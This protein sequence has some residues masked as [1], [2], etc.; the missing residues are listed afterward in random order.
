LRAG[1]G[2]KVAIEF[3][4]PV[5]AATVAGE[6]DLTVVAD[7][8]PGRLDALT[9]GLIAGLRTG[10]DGALQYDNVWLLPT[11][12]N[13]PGVFV[14]GGARG[15]SEWREAMTDGLAVAGQ[16]HD[17]L[18]GGT[19]APIKDA[20]TVD[21]DKCVL[22]LTC[23]RICPHGAIRIDDAKK[24]ASVSPLSCRRCGICA[25]EC[26]AVAIQLPGFSDNQMEARIGAKPRVTVFACENSAFPAA[27]T[28]GRKAAAR[29][30]MIKVPCAGK[31]D[32]RSVLDALSRGADKVLVLGCHPENCQ[33]LSGSSRASKRVER[34]GAALEKAG[35]DKSRV[36]FGGLASV[37]P[38]RF[39]E[40]VS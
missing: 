38:A 15:N 26:P 19:I 23:L 14:A 39:A 1:A 21:A 13:R 29:V 5:A 30:R 4:D 12:T 10:P 20:A 9:R 27:E 3:D 24:A 25:A 11:L 6:F 18:T 31:V 36:Q 40:Y 2:G 37:E 34:L 7:V 8:T 16:A 32:P 35:F 17:L 22:C 33:Y 28:A